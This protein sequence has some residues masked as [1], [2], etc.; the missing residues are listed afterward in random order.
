MQ[1]YGYDK[2]KS[3]ARLR[4]GAAGDEHDL[5]A[6]GDHGHGHD[7]DHGLVQD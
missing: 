6:N 3:N 1:S 2:I 4:R 7:H 5:H